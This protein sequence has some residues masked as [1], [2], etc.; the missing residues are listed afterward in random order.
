MFCPNCGYENNDD[1]MY[2]QNCGVLLPKNRQVHKAEV[3]NGSENNQNQ[4][5]GAKDDLFCCC[6]IFV[7][8]A[9]VVCVLLSF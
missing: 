3:I 9:G 2:C 6:C 4:D 8:I 1:E 7:L 5:E